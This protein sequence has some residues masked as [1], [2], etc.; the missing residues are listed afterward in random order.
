MNIPSP[1]PKR[2]KVT[3]HIAGTTKFVREFPLPGDGNV[4]LF[5]DDST[6]VFEDDYAIEIGG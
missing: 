4:W 2:A 3:Q 6:L 1:L 5:E